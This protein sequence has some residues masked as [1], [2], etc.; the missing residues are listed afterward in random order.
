MLS[1]MVIISLDV[2]TLTQVMSLKLPW[3]SHGPNPGASTA[4]GKAQ[5][6][7][8]IDE[9]CGG[10]RSHHRSS[11]FGMLGMLQRSQPHDQRSVQSIHRFISRC[12]DN[13]KL[14]CQWYLNADIGP[15]G[16]EGSQ[17]F[18]MSPLS[19]QSGFQ[20]WLNRELTHVLL[21]V[22]KR[23]AFAEIPE[24]QDFMDVSLEIFHGSTSTSMYGFLSN[25]SCM[26]SIGQDQGPRVLSFRQVR[27]LQD[28]LFGHVQGPQV[29][30][31]QVRFLQGTDPAPFGLSSFMT[32]CLSRGAGL[33]KFRQDQFFEGLPVD[34]FDS[35]AY[36]LSNKT[37]AINFDPGCGWHLDSESFWY[38]QAWTMI[39]VWVREYS[40]LFYA[41]KV[42][43]CAI[44][45]L[46][47]GL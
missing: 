21:D 29:L 46:S 45:V 39:Q 2:L 40:T 37:D 18:S 41:L 43:F 8:E 31:R 15:A 1:A 4:L 6:L 16:Q 28:V 47:Q 19:G 7:F 38:S 30:I 14:Q 34:N 13:P 23:V 36:L 11:N 33:D 10:M 3:T 32:V 22:S 24:G 25:G 44:Q 9:G 5:K 26:A 27:F 12:V 35:S 42:I 20:G 17:M